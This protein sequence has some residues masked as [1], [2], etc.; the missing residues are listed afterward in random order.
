MKRYVERTASPILPMVDDGATSDAP[1]T[2]TVNTNITYPD[3]GEWAFGKQ[4]SS[5]VS[6]CVC[7]QQLAICTVFFSFIGENILAVLERF[8]AAGSILD[9]HTAV[10]TLALPAVL[11]LS[12]M[13]NLKSLSPVMVAGT[14][15]MLV[16]FAFL[17]AIGWKEWDDRPDE[18]P[19]MNLPQIPLA[20]CAILYSYEGICLVLP[21]ESAMKEPQHFKSAFVWSMMS[22]AFILAAVASLSVYVFGDVNN[23]SITAFLLNA[24]RDDPSITLWLMLANTAVSLSILLTFPLQLFPALELMGPWL[25]RHLPFLKAKAIPNDVAE[26]SDLA[27]FEPLPPIGEHEEASLGSIPAQHD[28]GDYGMET[29]DEAKAD[30]EDDDLSRTMVSSVTSMFPEM[31]MPGDSPL[32][33]IL[34][35]LLTYSVAVV[36]PNVQTLISLAGAVAGSSVALLIPPVLELAWIQQLQKDSKDDQSC[37]DRYLLPKIKNWLLLSF[38]AVFMLIGSVA[39]ITDIVRIYSGAVASD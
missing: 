27:E 8:V 18:T 32:L 23:G 2:A 34:L 28:Y 30:V 26:D 17:G 22:V 16:G 38:G 21:V 1:S 13:P 36:V 14:V 39:S 7:V 4:F 12:F 3:L 11:S 19:T 24:Y 35:V 37:I 9:S 5:Y 15:L 6:A 29:N 25:S 20:V 33:R 31:T 10:L